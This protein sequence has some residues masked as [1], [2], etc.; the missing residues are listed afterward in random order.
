M[1]IGDFV[2]YV[3]G[4]FYEFQDFNCVGVVFRVIGVFD[5]VNLF[6]F[7]VKVLVYLCSGVVE[8]CV[9]VVVN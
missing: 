6:F 2:V 4:L 7:C 3:D 9:F 8:I 5:E 1:K